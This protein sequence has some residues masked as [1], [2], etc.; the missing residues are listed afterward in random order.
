MKSIKT[1]SMLLL[2]ISAIATKSN[3]VAIIQ[4][5]DQ[6]ILKQADQYRIAGNFETAKYFYMLIINK[7]PEVQIETYLPALS[8]L[9]YIYNLEGDS[10]TAIQYFHSVIGHCSNLFQNQTQLNL[11]NI[12]EYFLGTHMKL[13]EIYFAMERDEYLKIAMNHY[14]AIINFPNAQQIDLNLYE[15]CLEQ[16]IR[17]S[18]MIQKIQTGLP[19]ASGQCDQM[20][21]DMDFEKAPDDQKRTIPL[22]STPPN[23]K[24]KK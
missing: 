7:Y 10:I 1:L 3:G 24:K 22:P 17:I 18:Q 19:P 14:N 21:M 20:D 6:L 5:D 11:Q 16:T 23:N 12:T 4:C 9:G 2:L 15:H 13:G 8:N